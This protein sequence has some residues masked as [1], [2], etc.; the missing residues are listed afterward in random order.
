VLPSNG[1]QPSR[2]LGVLQG[3]ALARF[4]GSG[5]LFKDGVQLQQGTYTHTHFAYQC[6]VNES[7]VHLHSG[8]VIELLMHDCCTWVSVGMSRSGMWLLACCMALVHV[9][10]GLLAMSLDLGPNQRAGYTSF[11]PCVISASHRD[12]LKTLAG[13]IVCG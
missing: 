2:G 8:W 10:Q 7:L 12:L 9:G 11:R 4:F 6:G 13:D 3:C 5:V 1:Q